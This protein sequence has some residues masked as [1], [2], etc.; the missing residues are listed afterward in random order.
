MQPQRNPEVFKFLSFSQKLKGYFSTARFNEVSGKIVQSIVG[1]FEDA[2]IAR[3]C[4]PMKYVCFFNESGATESAL[5]GGKGTNLGKM[6][7]AGFPVPPGFCISTDAYRYLIEVTGLGP[8]IA[9]LIAGIDF[10]ETAVVEEKASHIR[11]LISQQ[12][13]P[14]HIATEIQAAYDQLGTI[15]G[16]APSQMLP[17]AVRSS[18]TAEDITDASFAGQQDTYLNVRGQQSVLEHVRRCWASLWTARA[19]SYR[20]K[21]GFDQQQVY[22]AVVVQS[23]IDPETSGIAFTA[24]PISGNRDEC[25]INA[26]WGLGEAIVS[27]LASPDTYVVRKVDGR[28]SQKH[29]AYKEQMITPGLEGGAVKV[30][31]AAHLRDIPALS[32]RQVAELT[33]LASRIEAY[34]GTPQ[35]IEW[36]NLNGRWYILQSRPI[37]TLM[38]KGQIDVVP[39]TYS[40]AMLVEIFIEVPHT[41]NGDSILNRLR[42]V[43]QKIA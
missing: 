4:V 28:I 3:E 38:E 20:H 1:T 25:V 2:V 8:I 12:P 42:R 14:L 34:Y 26:S 39:G 29:I 36:A 24:N 7:R 23:M 32:D 21:Q 5:V 18:A 10:Q 41:R 19:I 27:G 22:L 35:D 13:I 30:E 15:I 33:A 40:R 11:E 6:A 9:R 43:A 17:V 31:T 37:T 16:E